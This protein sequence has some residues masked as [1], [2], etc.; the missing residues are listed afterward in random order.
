MGKGR[1]R[2]S[3]PPDRRRKV[4]GGRRTEQEQPAFGNGPPRR[5]CSPKGNPRRLLVT[6]EGSRPSSRRQSAWRLLLGSGL[7]LAYLLVPGMLAAHVIMEHGHEPHHAVVADF[8]CSHP[9]H[10]Q[11]HP[12][13]ESEA[14]A[15]IPGHP[16]HCDLCD[17]MAFVGQ[18]SLVIAETVCFTTPPAI[19]A[20][21]CGSSQMVMPPPAPLPPARAPPLL[22]VT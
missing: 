1:R 9:A 14:P 18:S 15:G 8:G 7:L 11:D 6:V 17:F 12:A 5:G 4:R 2:R 19:A 22:S 10:H 3:R 20:V 16:E 21:I 13:G